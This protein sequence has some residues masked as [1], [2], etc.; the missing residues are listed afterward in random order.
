[1]FCKVCFVQNCVS[2]ARRKGNAV[3]PVLKSF[4][5]KNT[6]LPHLPEYECPTNGHWT[7]MC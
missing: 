3:C 2:L 1:M 5:N 6:Q 4:F 7:P